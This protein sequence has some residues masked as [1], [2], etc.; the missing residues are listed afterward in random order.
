MKKNFKSSNFVD[1]ASH[2]QNFENRQAHMVPFGYHSPACETK[3]NSNNQWTLW[4]N[5]KS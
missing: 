5:Y 2:P 1:T 4:A 3:S